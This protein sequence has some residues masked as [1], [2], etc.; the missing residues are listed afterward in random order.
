MVNSMQPYASALFD[1]AKED[2]KEKAYLEDLKELKMVWDENPDFVSALA[3]P[4][5]DRNT[6]RQWIE[7]IFKKESDPTVLNFLKVLVDHSLGYR[8]DDVYQDYLSLYR[9]DQG[10]EEVSVESAQPLSDS[11]IES[12]MQLL[13]KKLK[14][15]IELNITVDPS[16][17]AGIRIKAKDRVI[18]NTIDTRLSS[19][20]E[21]INEK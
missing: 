16:L 13:E 3:H 9:K 15:K 12:L 5:I 14:K 6:K 10:I 4:K 11:Q 8:L 17:I 20:K 2:G 18:D 7:A 19:L 1:I 21:R